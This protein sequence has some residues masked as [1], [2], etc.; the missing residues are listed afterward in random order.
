MKLRIDYGRCVGHGRC[1]AVAPDLFTDNDEGY[2]EVTV[3]APDDAQLP[4]ARLAMN[5]C[6]E[7]AVILEDA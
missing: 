1:Y 4:A 3:E 6:P 7:R 2:G 5:N